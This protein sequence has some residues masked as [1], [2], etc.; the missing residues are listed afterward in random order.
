MIER[1]LAGTAT[2][3]DIE[4]AKSYG[5]EDRKKLMERLLGNISEKAADAVLLDNAMEDVANSLRKA[6]PVF[7][8]GLSADQALGFI[9][10][11]V[12]ES[13]EELEESGEADSDEY[14]K[15]EIVLEKLEG[16][17]QACYD[18]GKTQG[19]EA[20]DAAHLEYRGEC[21][22]LEAARNECES[23]IANSIEFMRLAYGEGNEL[24]AFGK[25]IDHDLPCM[26]FI[27]KFGSPSFFAFKRIAKPGESQKAMFD[28]E[29]D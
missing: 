23:S 5:F 21:G 2:A 27:G 4:L 11:L 24:A 7:A 28:S 12:K 26:R 8:A 18:T 3:E 6:R 17:L 10:K 14:E 13:L 15:Q 19:E 29:G 16:I 20:Q 9:I 1:I 25:G 22:Q